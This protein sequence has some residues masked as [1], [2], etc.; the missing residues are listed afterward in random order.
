MGWNPYSHVELHRDIF[1]TA[2]PEKLFTP[3]LPCCCNG[4]HD[5]DDDGD[6]D[7][8]DIDN[9]TSSSSSSV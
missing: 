4:P 6:D 1:P 3:L 5:V 7:V 8:D 9:C 2:T